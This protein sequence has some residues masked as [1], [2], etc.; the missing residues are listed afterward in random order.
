MPLS[1][2]N[3]EFG[4]K[5]GAAAKA[6]AAMVKEY[7]AKKGERVFYAT[8]NKHKGGGNFEPVANDH[9]F[10]ASLG[11]PAQDHNH[12]AETPMD[13]GTFHGS[14][15]GGAGSASAPYTPS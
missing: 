3:K 8:K 9:D 15:S 13:R 12:D 6:H 11:A 14:R 10:H 4:G 2:Y 7:G 5:P 1:K